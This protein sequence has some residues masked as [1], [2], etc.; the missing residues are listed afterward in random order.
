MS[1]ESGALCTL[2]FSAA[3]D[4]SGKRYH[5]MRQSAE[6]SC[7]M[8]SLAT[9]SA[10]IGVLQNKPESGENATI[11]YSGKSKVTAGAA[12]TAGAMVT[13]NGSGRAVAVASGGMAGGR[14]LQAA[15][16]DGE[17]ISVLLFPPI[18]WAGAI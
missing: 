17:I 7:N 8:G 4:L 15:G 2:A 18:R 14:A 6:G 12:V 11:A 5:F 13:T 3:A 10:L 16:A 9:N 1:G